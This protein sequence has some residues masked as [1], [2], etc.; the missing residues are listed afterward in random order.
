M[1]AQLDPLYIKTRPRKAVIRILSHL[2]FQGRFLTTKYR[3]LNHFILAELACLK[4]LPQLRSV[5]EPIFIV[6]TGRS[7]STILGKVL[8]MHRDIG[9]LNE[10]KALWYSIDSREDVNGHFQQ[11][12]AQ[13]RFN[14]SDATSDKYRMAH[15]LFGAYLTLTGSK[16]VLD[17]NP[18]TV[19][20]IPFVRAIFP[21]A[22]F[23]FLV[24]NGWDTVDSIVSW[25]KREGKQIRGETQDWWGVNQRKWRLMVEQLVP[26]EPLLAQATSE[27]ESLTQHKDMAAVEWIVTMQEGLRIANAIPDCIYM[28]RYEDLVQYPTE[29]MRALADFCNLPKDLTF[30]SYAQVLK[31]NVAKDPVLLPSTINEAFLNTMRTLD[32]RV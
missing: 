20:R 5:E 18:E 22:K 27:I 25:S 15:R 14:E 16:R 10:P 21:D 26:T 9:F 30:L 31:P 4:Y 13:Y 28:L 19:F 7:G 3:W 12:A 23:I 1:I 11:G 29:T 8:S 17:K 2:F 32:Y 6:G 24:R